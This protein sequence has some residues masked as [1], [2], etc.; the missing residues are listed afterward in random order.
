MES[1]YHQSDYSSLINIALIE[2]FPLKPT[3]SGS[4]LA[5]RLSLGHEI[6]H[7]AILVNRHGDFLQGLVAAVRTE[8]LQHAVGDSTASHVWAYKQL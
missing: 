7:A 5:D 1:I 2:S 8:L 3:H 6:M 4:A